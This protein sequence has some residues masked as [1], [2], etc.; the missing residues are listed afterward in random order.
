MHQ[1]YEPRVEDGGF[2]DLIVRA[3]HDREILNSTMP[4]LFITIFARELPFWE[5]APGGLPSERFAVPLAQTG[6]CDSS[7]ICLALKSE[8]C[9][10]FRGRKGCQETVKLT[11][12]FVCSNRSRETRAVGTSEKRNDVRKLCEPC[13]VLTF[14]ELACFARVASPGGQR[15]AKTMGSAFPRSDANPLT[16]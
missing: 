7:P 10:S 2:M 3:C 1:D 15:S 8:R 12:V 14:V 9:R 5:N 11:W 6:G 13:S 16:T 4:Y